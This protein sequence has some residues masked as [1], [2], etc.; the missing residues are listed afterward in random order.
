MNIALL[1]SSNPFLIGCTQFLCTAFFI[2]CH[3]YYK[4]IKLVEGLSNKMA[5]F[6]RSKLSDSQQGN[7]EIE[8]IAEIGSSPI[9]SP[10]TQKE[11]V[12]WEIRITTKGETVR[13]VHS[14]SPFLINDEPNTKNS[15]LTRAL[16]CPSNR[17][18]FFSPQHK[19]FSA[20]LTQEIVKINPIFWQ[21]LKIDYAFTEYILVET[22]IYPND[23]VYLTGHL[24]TLK[25]GYSKAIGKALANDDAISLERQLIKKG[26]VSRTFN[27]KERPISL[28][29]APLTQVAELGDF[30]A[31]QR[32]HPL[33]SKYLY[34]TRE[35]PLLISTVTETM[36]DSNQAIDLYAISEKSI[37]IF[38]GSLLFF[39]GCIISAL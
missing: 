15:R 22:V 4:N 5:A 6:Q 3:K 24:A 25:G 18:Q 34:G 16:V 19:S 13:V 29:G 7:I 35:S 10:V 33:C 17:T 11:C 38:A 23:Q 21:K 39:I 9:L 36:M 20:D 37:A 12:F 14:D 2:L 32:E 31:N 27:N 30:S 8:G 28:T 26:L 1:V